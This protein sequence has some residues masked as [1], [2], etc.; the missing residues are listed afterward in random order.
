MDESH[1]ERSKVVILGGGIGGL[2]AAFTLSRT[3]ELRDRYDVTVYQQGWRLGGKGASG[4]NPHEHFRIEEHG[5]HVFPGF[6]ENAFL[7]MRECYDV[8]NRPPASPLSRCFDEP[9][10][11][12]RPQNDVTVME[13]SNG[14]W[15]PWNLTFP[16]RDGTPGD[17]GE[18]PDAWQIVWELCQWVIDRMGSFRDVLHTGPEDAPGLHP[19]RRVRRIMGA[20]SPDNLEDLLKAAFEQI[21]QLRRQRFDFGG[22]GRKATEWLLASFRDQ[23]NAHVRAAVALSNDLRRLWILMQLAITIALG[24]IHDDVPTQ[25]FE[26]LDEYDFME[27]LQRHGAPY[28]DVAWSPVVVSIYAITFAYEPHDTTRRNLA[29]GVALRATMRLFFTYRDAFLWKMQAGMGETVFAPIYQV[30]LQ[31][32]VQF[33]FFH[34][35]TKLEL[36]E[37]ET[38]IARVHIN[39]QVTLRN[40][41]YEPLIDVDGLPCWP[42]QPRYEQIDPAEATEL[43][44]LEQEGRTLESAWSS[45][46]DREE[47]VLRGENDAHVLNGEDELDFHAVVLA[48][49]VAALPPLCEDLASADDSWRNML[50]RLATVQTVSMQLWLNKSNAELGATIDQVDPVMLGFARPFDSYIGMTQLCDREQFPAGDVLHIGY[51]CSPID[52][53]PSIPLPHSDSTFPANQQRRVEQIAGD[54]LDN[55]IQHYWTNSRDPNNPRQFDRGLLVSE[56]YR[57]NINPTD[58]YT[59]SLTDT[60]RFRIRPDVSGFEQLYVAGDWTYNGLN[61]GCIEATVMSGMRAAEGITGQPAGIIGEEDAWALRP[62]WFWRCI[63]WFR[64]LFGR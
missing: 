17:G 23:L 44:Q 22:R 14:D 18:F 33:Q 36:S 49:P 7:M 4:C 19:P 63:G 28:P 61:V 39:R 48:I 25:G 35:V 43:V 34:R 37:D 53:A 13:R 27:W 62:N 54:Y 51:F 40:G 9:N 20:R 47:I 15:S 24:M 32:G 2:T 55:E 29:A 42:S 26:P 57:I 1:P 30:L 58:R 50:D 56:Y 11:A 8:L 31:R 21:A 5:I 10:P 60:T 3:P 6:Y 38:S 46:Q 45:W 12:F 16:R 59:L 41:P 52:D 64:R